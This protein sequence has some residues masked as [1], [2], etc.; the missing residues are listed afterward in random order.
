MQSFSINVEAL[1]IPSITGSLPTTNVSQWNHLE[2]LSLADPQLGSRK[3][4]ELLLGADVYGRLV[5][6]GQIPS[7]NGSPIALNTTLGWYFVVK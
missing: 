4:V 3:R 5:L 1:T 6:D 2:H 7:V